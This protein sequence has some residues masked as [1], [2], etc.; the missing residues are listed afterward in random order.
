MS[1]ACADI[2]LAA[3]K[4][5]T[6][7][8]PAQSAAEIMSAAMALMSA[9]YADI[10]ETPAQSPTA[11]TSAQSADR[12]IMSAACAEMF[13]TTQSTTAILTVRFIQAKRLAEQKVNQSERMFLVRE[14]AVSGAAR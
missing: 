6:A 1:A 8:T 5:P 13:I 14:T 2:I 4:S 11:I 12:I 10:P 3:A 7:I 9:A